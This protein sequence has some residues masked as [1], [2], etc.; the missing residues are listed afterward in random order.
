MTFY[1]TGLPTVVYPSHSMLRL[2][3]LQNLH[4]V[5][6]AGFTMDNN[7]VCSSHMWL[8]KFEFFFNLKLSLSITV[9]TFQEFNDHMWM[10]PTGRNITERSIRQ[11]LA[12]AWSSSTTLASTPFSAGHSYL[13][14]TGPLLPPHGCLPATMMIALPCY[15]PRALSGHP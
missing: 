4:H 1:S 9:S 2:Q 6:G 14:Q 15:P 13:P 11:Q 8:F 10:Y 5:P 7:A 3:L 12:R